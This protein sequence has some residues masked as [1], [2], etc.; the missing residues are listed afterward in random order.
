MSEL[1][2]FDFVKEVGE[3]SEAHGFHSVNT[4]AAEYL[5]LIHSEVSEVLEELRSGHSMNEVYYQKGSEKPEGVP[6][7]LAD[8]VIRCFDMAYVFG[9]DLE[10]WIREKHEFNKSRPFLHG[11]K[12]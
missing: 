2:I 5:A 3:N 9:I 8:V 11:K 10:H 12:F 7:E 4:S 1:K 6:I